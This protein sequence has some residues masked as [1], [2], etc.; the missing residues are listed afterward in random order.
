MHRYRLFT[1]AIA[2]ALA[3]RGSAEPVEICRIKGSAAVSQARGNDFQFGRI[4]TDASECD[5]ENA[6][7][8]VSAPQERD[9]HCRVKLFSGQRLNLG[10][11]IRFIAVEFRPQSAQFGL[12]GS[13]TGWTLTL[14]VPKGK[15]A[16][17]TVKKVHLRGPDCSHWRRAFD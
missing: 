13:P 2:L 3:A 8:V 7:V 15:T 4:D 5:L 12:S 10:W 6:S 16:M 11:D 14:T 17:F 1:G 9:G